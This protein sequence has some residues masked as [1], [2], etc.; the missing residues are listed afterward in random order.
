MKKICLIVLIAFFCCQAVAQETKN[1]DIS[2]NPIMSSFY[3]KFYD[4]LL[5]KI[6]Q[7]M[8][9]RGMAESRVNAYMNV[10]KKR[11][12]KQELID[13]TYPCFAEM[14]IG[15]FKE[16]FDKCFVPWVKK[17]Q[18]KNKDLQDVLE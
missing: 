6:E 5:K 7:R 4:N 16:A 9:S 18:E 2:D 17:M 12:K 15:K 8:S 1:I 13:E 11:L 14:P 3:D 10:L